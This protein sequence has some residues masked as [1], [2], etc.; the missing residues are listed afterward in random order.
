VTKSAT[1]I[2]DKAFIGSD[3]TLVAP[4]RVGRGAYIG[5]ASCITEDVPEG[6]L[7]LSRGRQV[8][9]EGWAKERQARAKPAAKK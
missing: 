8:T 3:T 6:A 1:V 5:A 4:V 7:A 9:K 2:E